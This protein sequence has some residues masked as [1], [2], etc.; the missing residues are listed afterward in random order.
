MFLSLLGLI[1]P[2]VACATTI[3]TDAIRFTPSNLPALCRLGDMRLDV[4][5]SNIEACTA[6]NTW[7]TVVNTISGSTTNHAVLLGTGSSAINSSTVGTTGQLLTGATGADPTWTTL[8]QYGV[9]VGAGA[10]APTTIAPDA[11]TI[12]VLTSGGLSANPT[13]AAPSF[14]NYAVTSKTST[15]AILT[16]D[17]VVLCSSAAFTLTLPTAV[18][19][20]GKVYLIKK[21]DSST[22]NICTIATTSAQTINGFSGA[23]LNQ[24]FEY[25]QVVSDGSNWQV[26]S[27][28]KHPTLT[29]FVGAASGTYTPPNQ[30]VRL[31]VIAVGAGGGG[32][33]AGTSGAGNGTTTTATTF[34]SSLVTANP[35]A[36]AVG[37]AGAAGAGGTATCAGASSGFGVS[38]GAGFPAAWQSGTTVVLIS[39]AGGANPLGGAGQPA[40]STNTGGAGVSGTGAGGAG[41]G[42]NTTANDFGGPGG[43]AGGYAACMVPTSAAATFAYATF[44][45]GAGGA[46]GG[47]GG[48]GGAGGSGALYIYEDYQ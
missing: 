39:G 42:I 36:G 47:N 46:G 9:V 28:S 18:G 21:T 38:G 5:S 40:T 13:W 30:A 34:G 31:R 12:K 23:T 32:G 10:A 43:G 19:V 11:S 29:Q 16:T 14:G 27:I 41:G 48:T 45:G 17:N 3:T 25:I 22:A 33:G 1:T 4:V 35:G 24:Q 20:T 15:Y 26:V 8:S 37:G 7:I 44:A 6:S 2:L